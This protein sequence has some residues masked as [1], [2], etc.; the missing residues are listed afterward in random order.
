LEQ[1]TQCLQSVSEQACLL[2]ACGIKRVLIQDGLVLL[3]ANGGSAKVAEHFAVD[4]GRRLNSGCKVQALTA[5]TGIVT[6][7][8]NDVGY[9]DI[10]RLQVEHSV[11]LVKCLFVMSSSGESKNLIKAAESANRL[12]VHVFGLIGREG[13]KLQDHCS[14][15]L[16]LTGEVCAEVAEDVFQAVCHQVVRQIAQGMGE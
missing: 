4:L 8:G 2:L 16:V 9:G 14:Y 15:A 1:V 11:P 6:A 5:N 3:A 12:G 7:W 13:S 10:F